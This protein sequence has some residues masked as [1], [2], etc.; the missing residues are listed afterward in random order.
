MALFQPSHELPDARHPRDSKFYVPAMNQKTHRRDAPSCR[1]ASAAAGAA[2]AASLVESTRPVV[3]ALGPFLRSQRA[4][5][6]DVVLAKLPGF[7]MLVCFRLR[8]SRVGEPEALC[9][10]WPVSYAGGERD[11]RLFREGAAAGAAADSSETAYRFCRAAAH[12]GPSLCW[13]RY[14]RPKALLRRAVMDNIIMMR[15]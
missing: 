11:A 14:T 1:S 2:G 10:G 13:L 3:L 7:P 4:R 6:G 8:C 9:P 15:K 12:G 5:L